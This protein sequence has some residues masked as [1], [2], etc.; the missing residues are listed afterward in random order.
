MENSQNYVLC[1]GGG[2]DVPFLLK[3]LPKNY[4]VVLVDKNKKAPAKK[5]AKIFI[6]CSYLNISEI[7]NHLQKLGIHKK[8]KNILFRSSGEIT[9]KIH[10]LFKKLKIDYMPE[11]SAKILTYKDNLVTFCEKNKILVPK[12][13]KKITSKKFKKP[14]NLL[15]RPALASGKRGVKIV[16]KYEYFQKAIINSKNLSEN[17]KVLI[18]KFVEGRDIGLIGQCI[19][20]KFEKIIFM[21]EFMDL[22]KKRI[23]LKSIMAQPDISEQQKLYCINIAQKI[24][25]ILK[26]KKSQLNIQ[27]KINSKYVYL[28]EVHL[29]FPGDQILENLYLGF[30]KDILKIQIKNFLSNKNKFYNERFKN[31]KI[32]LYWDKIK[33]NRTKNFHLKKR[34]KYLA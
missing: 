32:F 19:N 20:G 9:F 13:F 15:V 18:Q 29:N 16:K 10:E 2:K 3:K 7:Y 33:K 30:K 5:Y 31:I 34:I 24:C 28:I 23:Y 22:K 17:K 1:I 12:T 11:S 6:N 26:I 8:I 4:N 21:E 27:F 25:K 14:L